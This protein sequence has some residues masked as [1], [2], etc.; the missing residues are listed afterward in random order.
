MKL[1]ALVTSSARPPVSITV[2]VPHDGSSS[3]AVCHSVLPGLH[4]ERRDEV[5]TRRIDLDDDPVAPD[6]RRAGRSPLVSGQIVRAHVH[7]PEVA[8]PE[9]RALQVVGVDALRSER[10]DDDGVPS[11]AGAGARVGGLDVA[12]VDRHALRRHA[13]PQLLAGPAIVGDDQPLLLGSIG[14]RR[15]GTVE[16][17]LE[18]RVARLLTADVTNTRSPQTIGLE[19]ARPGTRTCQRTLRPAA[20]SHVSGNCWPVATPRSRAPRNDGHGALRPPGRRRA[21]PRLHHAITA[22]APNS[23]ELAWESS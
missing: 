16:T 14:G 18:A 4:V 9:Q 2:G 5:G 12:L 7:A 1:G 15:A 17:G 8:L 20:T 22:A 13:L 10:G 21:C 6:D 19:C 3:R 23:D 11:V